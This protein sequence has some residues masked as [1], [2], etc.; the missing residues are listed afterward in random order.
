MARGLGAAGIQ[1]NNVSFLF[2][3]NV[4]TMPGFTNSGTRHP[5][6]CESYG[7]PYCGIICYMWLGKPS[8]IIALTTKFLVHWWTKLCWMV[9]LN[10]WMHQWFLV[11]LF[12]TR[13]QIIF[14]DVR[15]HK[16]NW[17]FYYFLASSRTSCTV[18]GFVHLLSCF[19]ETRSTNPEVLSRNVTEF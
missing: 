14:Y 17:C 11:L 12:K 15:T 5:V 3:L 8:I 2:S 6:N 13:V 9:V 1:H 19:P 10:S 18:G 4:F 7:I 16:V